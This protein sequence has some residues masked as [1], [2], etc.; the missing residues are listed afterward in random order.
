MREKGFSQRLILFT[1]VLGAVILAIVLFLFKQELLYQPQQNPRPISAKVFE[2][3]PTSYPDCLKTDQKNNYSNDEIGLKC[4]FSIN[5]KVNSSKYEQCLNAGGR[6]SA[7]IIDTT[8]TPGIPP[9]NFCEMFFYNPN[10]VFPKKFEECEK[11]HKGAITGG[12]GSTQ[13][14]ELVPKACSVDIDVGQA[15]DKDVATKL[16]NQCRNLGGYYN[17][18]QPGCFLSFE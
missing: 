7:L 2:G 5:Q 15:F 1:V 13:G 8:G 11:E 6:K 10:Y 16:L 12:D 14:G 3:I 17:E 18:R 9:E 4:Q